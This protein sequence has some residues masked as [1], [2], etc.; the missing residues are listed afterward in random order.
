[1]AGGHRPPGRELPVHRLRPHGPLRPGRVLWRQ[2]GERQPVRER[3]GRRAAAGHPDRAQCA[4]DHHRALE[5]VRLRAAP[6]HGPGVP[7]RVRREERPARGEYAARG[8]DEAGQRAAAHH[9]LAGRALPLPAERADR[10]GDHDGDR[11][12]WNPEGDRFRVV[13]A[14][15]QQVHA[16]RTAPD[17]RPQ[18]GQRHL[19]LRHPRHAR[20]ALRVRGGT[21]RQHDQPARVRWQRQ[22][23]LCIQHAD[24]D[25]AA[26]FPHRPDGA[27][28]GRDRREVGHHFFLCHR[29]RQ[30]GAEAAWKVPDRQGLELGRDRELRVSAV[31]PAQP[32]GASVARPAPRPIFPWAARLYQPL[33]PFAYTL[34]RAATGA[35]FIPHGIQKLFL[36]TAG[37]PIGYVMGGLELLGGLLILFGILVRPVA[38]MLIIDVL[39]VIVANMAKGWLWTRGG[40]QYHTFLLGMV[41]AVFIGGAGRHAVGSWVIQR[42]DDLLVPFAYAFARIWFAL[43]ILPSGYEKVF[44]D[45]AARIAAGNVLKTGFYPPMFWAW[46]VALLEFVGMI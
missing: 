45:G 26:R 40:V 19:G 29:S 34:I 6:R 28:H 3:Q 22:A 42:F 24:G 11:A 15:G 12:R 20:R 10:D 39:M 23:H 9:Q 43:L 1:A 14:G 18:R 30:R 38:L 31:N 33:E 21:H 16:G 13:L 46:V 25:A 8:A 37:G 5:Q 41:I 36:G 27:L 17:T 32:V 44:S 7:V 35:I 2:P 4:L